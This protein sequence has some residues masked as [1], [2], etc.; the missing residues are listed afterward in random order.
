MRL[1]ELVGLQWQDVDL[2]EGVLYVRRQH[3]WLGEYAPPKTKAAIRRIPLSE[4]MTR[5]LAALGLRSRYSSDDDPVFAARN[6][7]PLKHRNATRRGFEAAAE[8]AGIKGVIVPL[9]AACVRVT[10]DRPWHLL[11]RARGADGARVE[12]DHRAPLRPS[13]RPAAHRRG[14]AAGDGFR[15]SVAED[16]GVV[17]GTFQQQRCSTEPCAALRELLG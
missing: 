15:D 6:G 3:T 5:E 2:H 17:S 14:G 11:D 1:G 13:V 16:G 7:K 12:H 9:D 8:K 10:D 4:E